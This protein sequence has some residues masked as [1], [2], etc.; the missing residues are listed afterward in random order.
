MWYKKEQAHTSS[1]IL[2][3]TCVTVSQDFSP[4]RIFPEDP[5]YIIQTNGNLTLR[6][7]GKR[8]I[9]WT[10]ETYTEE[11]N[12][13]P[14]YS[15][16]TI[17]PSKTPDSEYI[18]GSIL[19]IQN[20]SYM[21]T[22]YYYCHEINNADFE[23]EA[24]VLLDVPD[25]EGIIVTYNPREGFKMSEMFSDGSIY[26]CIFSRDGVEKTA[27][28]IVDVEPI[29]YSIAK[30]YIEEPSGGHTTVGEKLVL[31][32]SLKV[33]VGFMMTW[34][35]PDRDGIKNGRINISKPMSDYTRSTTTNTFY[36]ILTIEETTLADQGEYI[37]LV[38]DANHENN[39]TK[40]V[41][42]FDS[43]EHFI[44][45]TEEN[46]AYNI[47][48]LAGKTNVQWIID[49][50]AHPLAN[51]AW[52]NNK[53]E[54]IQAGWSD[55]KNLQKYE[56]YTNGSNKAILKIYNVTINDRGF[57][58]LKAITEF[59]E[60]K[61]QLFLN[62]ADK[63]LVDIEMN[64]FHMLNQPSTVI[65]AVAAYPEASVYW[66][67]K[68]CQDDSCEYKYKKAFKQEYQNTLLK[69][70]LN[71]T[72]NDS[73]YVRCFANNSLG[74]DTSIR[75]YLVTDVANGFGIWGLDEDTIDNTTGIVQY[76]I[77]INEVVVLYCAASKYNYTDQL[78]WYINNISIQN[79]DNYTIAKSET[80]LS[81]KLTLSIESITKE[82]SGEYAC[83][84]IKK[85]STDIPAAERIK[86]EQIIITVREPEAPIIIDSNLNGSKLSINLPEK[87]EMWCYAKGI[88]KP[89][90]IWYKNGVELVEGTDAKE[91]MKMTD[92]NSRIIFSGTLEADEGS[93]TC[94]AVNKVGTDTR[95][96]NLRFKNKPGNMTNYIISFLVVILVLVI[97]ISSWLIFR[98]RKERELH[99]ELKKVG[100]EN[101][102]NGALESLNPDLGVDDQAELLPYDK[103][104]E[105]PRERLKLG[106]QLG[107][108]A[109]G[110]VMKAEANAIVDGEETTIVAVKMVKRQADP[111]YIKALASELKIMVHLGKHLNVVN[112]LGACTKNV[113]KRELFVIVEYC[114]FGNVHNY[115]LRHRDSF[116]DQ[117]D[118]KTGKI[119]YALGA[120]ISERSFSV[121]SSKSNN[122]LLSNSYSGGTGST[123]VSMSPT[124]EGEDSLLTSNNSAQ[125]E[126]RSNYHGDYKGKVKTICT[127]DL[128]MWAFQVVRGMEYLTSRRVLH[129]DLA[130]RNIL[131]T[132]NNIVKICDFGLAK[133]M[134]KD[135]NYKKKGDAPLPVKW[136]AIESI[137]DRVFST[138]SDVWS[139]GIV[140]WEF[141]SL[142]RTP[143]PGME[144]DE[145][146]YN[147]LVDGYRM[148][149]PQYAT[150]E[151]YKIMCNCWH[152]IPIYRP[153]FTALAETIGRMLEESVKQFYVD[154]NEPYLVMNTQRFEEGQSDYLAMLSPP[155]FEHLSS[156]HTYVNDGVLPNAS[157]DS[158]DTPGY[159][160]MK[161][162]HILNP[163]RE[164]ENIV[165]FDV[166]ANNKKH[167]GEAVCSVELLP[168]LHTQS[169][170]D[171]ETPGLFNQTP[172]TPT[173]Y[174]NPSYHVPPSIIERTDTDVV[175]T[176]DNYVNM[177]QNKSA[178]K[179]DKIVNNNFNNPSTNNYVNTSSADWEGI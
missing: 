80:Q 147:K 15:T 57:Y 91:R 45:L 118:A 2:Q 78:Q 74:N 125:P 163:R 132:E 40:F 56:V 156:P 176:S 16:I 5:E 99:R 159:L 140:L 41:R 130:A 6:C 83:G 152:P 36:Q 63:P 70:Y 170:S 79:S 10:P 93:Y 50:E 101:F 138:Q 23:N 114:Q 51:L 14:K 67:Y 162:T 169:E 88:P 179:S 150:K 129:G 107:A 165:N 142:A 60:K 47:S 153:S 115:L 43:G 66:Y 111:M 17:S 121:S 29:T 52:Y 102:E 19:T 82:D 95:E 28:I 49:V 177:P 34:I 25:E 13:E 126:W 133:S 75:E 103:K 112:L 154:L 87:F 157:P 100:L 84:V 117:I 97:P 92:G 108:G 144:A 31:R 167:N 168:M 44:N 171:C 73:G 172:E 18:Y 137:R 38:K 164:Q 127:K 21:D 174:S 7:E 12:T 134:Y 32:C 61:L 58:Y 146:L 65:C 59:E 53:D 166:D 160:C 64:S 11:E 3:R 62:V 90:M 22:G 86:N 113:A 178:T 48:V 33:D 116:I 8:P 119:D 151:M 81:Y 30:P 109:F 55:N 37:C 20:A 105:F 175:K 42:I 128:I 106:K 46:G 143:Y 158:V 122:P 139:Y 85:G 135:D 141:F 35:T 98:L 124:T 76:P 136:M 173:S 27:T 39:N 155:D 96:M 131:L 94:K 26:E 145:R 72:A 24:K 110:V 120:D 1:T 69:S 71:I 148:D 161:S 54:E 123:A 9:T 4:P 77:A 149:S 89:S 104:W 68:D